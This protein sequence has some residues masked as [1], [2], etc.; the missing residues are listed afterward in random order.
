VAKGSNTTIYNDGNRP[1]TLSDGRVVL[2]GERVTWELPEE[3]GDQFLGSDDPD[4]SNLSVT[5]GGN[6][7]GD[8]APDFIEQDTDG[9]TWELQ[10]LRGEVVWLGL[11]QDG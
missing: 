3:N 9:K 8:P 11:F 4:E 2:P 1:L 7:I 10:A 6:G 5:I